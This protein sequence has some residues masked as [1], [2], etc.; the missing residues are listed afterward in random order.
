MKPLNPIRRIVLIMMFLTRPQRAA[1]KAVYDRHIRCNA[2]CEGTSYRQFRRL[3]FP[4]IGDNSC[5]MIKVPGMV[6]GIEAKDGATH[7]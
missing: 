6:L 4:L 2:A 3:V 5:A 7:S 1:L